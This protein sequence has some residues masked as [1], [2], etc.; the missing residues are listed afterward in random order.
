[1]KQALRLAQSRTDLPPA[2]LVALELV[3]LRAQ[4][5]QPQGGAP[6]AAGEAC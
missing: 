2:Y 1:M 5:D 6:E 3:I 4:K